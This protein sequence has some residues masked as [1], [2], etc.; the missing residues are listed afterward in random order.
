MFLLN[1]L[2]FLIQSKVLI[3]NIQLPGPKMFSRFN[4]TNRTLYVN[5]LGLILLNFIFILVSYSGLSFIKLYHI[6]LVILFFVLYF[7]PMKYRFGIMAILALDLILSLFLIDFS[8][9]GANLHWIAI[10]EITYSLNIYETINNDLRIDTYPVLPWLLPAAV[11]QMFPDFVNI[12]SFGKIYLAFLLFIYVLEYSIKYNSR[13]I[14]VLISLLISLPSIFL[15]QVYTGYVDYWTYFTACIFTVSLIKYNDESS[16]ENIQIIAL[17]LILLLIVKFQTVVYFLIFLPLLL[18]IL[19]KNQDNLIDY[20]KNYLINI[21]TLFT[22]FAVCF[23]AIYLNN[24]INY[25][26][27]V[28]FATE[29]GA[30][31]ILFDNYFYTDTDRWKHLYYSLFSRASLNTD[32]P[33][34]NFFYFPTWDEYI[35]YS[36]PDTR[37]GAS[38]PLFGILIIFLFALMFFI[39]NIIL[40]IICA[41]IVLSLFL[42][43]TG[44]MRYY[45]LI[46]GAPFIFLLALK[47]NSKQLLDIN[48]K[49]LG[50]NKIISNGSIKKFIIVLGLVNILFVSSSSTAYQGY[51]SYINLNFVENVKNNEPLAIKWNGWNYHEKYLEKLGVKFLSPEYVVE[52]Y[53]SSQCLPLK[54][55]YKVYTHDEVIIC[56]KS[57][58]INS[59]EK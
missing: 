31:K 12:T 50:K 46:Q 23:S 37:F 52:N 20:F 35:Q 10:N 27:I 1:A 16:I 21:I 57:L 32:S 4:E 26:S 18:Y 58:H 28:P 34:I 6:Y 40:Y 33:I 22:L 49:K 14:A 25:N 9:D 30:S 38:G 19:Y 51:K 5:L 11:K 2:D 45:P 43:G 47:D 41:Y 53:D 36:F 7:S 48:I 13:T 3:S 8:S 24:Y 54:N 55:V 39:K 44:I 17:I 59:Q 42:P 15:T 56:M 29:R